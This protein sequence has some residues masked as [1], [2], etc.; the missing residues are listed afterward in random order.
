MAS[1]QE[2]GVVSIVAKSP[3]GSETIL[4]TSNV[5]TL[6]PSGGAPDGASTSVV[7]PNERI[8]APVANHV[9]VNDDVIL[10]KFKATATDGV[11]ISDCIWS[12]PIQVSGVTGA[13]YLALGDFTQP[14]GVDVT[15]TA[16]I[17]TVLAGYKVTEGRVRFGGAPIYLDVQDDT[18]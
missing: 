17:E 14:T 9:L 7:K 6:A 2:A 3:N 11:D 12:I 16:G 4:M 5:A 13:K 18:A 10:V 15:A 8:F 1:L